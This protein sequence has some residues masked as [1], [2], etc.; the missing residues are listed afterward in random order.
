MTLSASKLQREAPTSAPCR[1]LLY[2]S[3]TV[4]MRGLSRKKQ[5]EFRSCNSQVLRRFPVTAVAAPPI[6]WK[7]KSKDKT[8]TWQSRSRELLKE[9]TKLSR[10]NNRTTSVSDGVQRSHPVQVVMAAGAC[11]THRNSSVTYTDVDLFKLCVCV[12]VGG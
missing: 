4:S 6:S 8:H 7:G 10:G 1:A 11:N 5:W 9:I 3:N 12:C 2:P